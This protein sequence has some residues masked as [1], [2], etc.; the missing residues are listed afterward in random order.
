MQDPKAPPPDFLE[1]LKVQSQ[2]TP[3]EARRMLYEDDLRRML[4]K[5]R[6]AQAADPHATFDEYGQQIEGGPRPPKMGPPLQFDKGPNSRHPDIPIGGHPEPKPLDW[7]RWNTQKLPVEQPGLLTRAVR[8]ANQFLDAHPG[9]GKFIGGAEHVVKGL[10]NQ[11]GG[12]L[13]LQDFLHQKNLEQY[14]RT[15][16]HP[17]WTDQQAYDH[18][19]GIT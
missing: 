16:G 3:E 19:H 11:M 10:G 8:G 1:R 5:E 12:V 2:L 15:M 17:E 18:Y 7:N 9:I 6:A 14:K 4:A 13:S